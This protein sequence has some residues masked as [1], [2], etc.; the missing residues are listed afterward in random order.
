MLL[1]QRRQ[2]G[3]PSHVQ[4]NKRNDIFEGQPTAPNHSFLFGHLLYLKSVL[5]QLPKVVH[6]HFAFATIVREDFASEGAFY[7]NLWPMSGHFHTVVSPKVAT[8]ITLTNPK[9][10]SDHPELLRR[11]LKCITG[12]LTIFDLG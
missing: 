3:F 9:L 8:E 2:E 7:I 5:D 11:L 4:K 1:I 6:Y 10:T 12:G